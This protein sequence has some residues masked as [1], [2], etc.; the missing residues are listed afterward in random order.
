M[1]YQASHGKLGCGTFHSIH[2]TPKPQDET[3]TY[4]TARLSCHTA[5]SCKL[6]AAENLMLIP[7]RV[8]LVIVGKA[9]RS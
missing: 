4:R 6:K 9:T 7:R 1:C 3:A 5:N 8:V 2:H